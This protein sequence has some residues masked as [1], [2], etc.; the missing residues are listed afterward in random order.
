MADIKIIESQINNYRALLKLIETNRLEE[1]FPAFTPVKI[2]L[3][4]RLDKITSFRLF[5]PYTPAS[6]TKKTMKRLLSQKAY[7]VSSGVYAYAQITGNHALK[8]AVYYSFSDFNRAVEAT[9][10]GR[11]RQILNAVKKVKNPEHCGLFPDVIEDLKKEID[12]FSEFM[13]SPKKTI[14]KRA[15]NRKKAKALLDECLA[16]IQN[17][18]DPLMQI[19]GSRDFPLEVSYRSRRKLDKCP[20]RRRKYVKKTNNQQNTKP[21]FI[22]ETQAPVIISKKEIENLEPVI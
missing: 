5:T 15:Q 19:V 9:C 2:F 3:M 21:A 14:K 10:I 7:N 12:T 17:Q 8:N 1:K 18:L 11:C 22:P 16:I 13:Q 6:G 4:Q 20:G